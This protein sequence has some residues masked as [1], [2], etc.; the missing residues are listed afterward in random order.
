MGME[1]KG[2]SVTVSTTDFES[3]SICSSHIIPA[4]IT[5]QGVD[6]ICYTHSRLCRLFCA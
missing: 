5:I 1:I 2:Y 3:V 6:T 4:K